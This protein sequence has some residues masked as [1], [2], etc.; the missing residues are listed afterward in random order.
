MTRSSARPMTALGLVFFLVLGPQADGQRSS[1]PVV[2]PHLTLLG[3]TLGKNTFTNVQSRFGG[4]TNGHCSDEAEPI[5]H[6]CYVSKGP[7]KTKIL[8]ESNRFDP[9]FELSGFRV[10]AARRSISPC[11]LQCEPTAA[12]GEGLQTSGGLK[13]GLTQKELIA[14]LGPPSKSK[15]N[16]LTFEWLSKRPMTKTEIDQETKTFKAPVTNPYWDVQD[17]I[18]VVL[19]KSSV[20]EFEVHHTV[21]D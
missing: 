16:R 1:K 21:T 14:L 9:P 2:L 6:I 5:A 20:V 7:D 3:F 19:S 4:A 17:I 11:Q 8:F 10:V 12:L 18:E 13:L 15:G